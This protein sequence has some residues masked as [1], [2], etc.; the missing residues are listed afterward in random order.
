MIKFAPKHKIHSFHPPLRTLM[1][2]GP[3]EMH[4]RVISAMGKPMVGY[5]DPVFVQM[6][7]ELKDRCATPTRPTMR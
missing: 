7:D 4:P 6:M 2:P 5:I 1:G 3:S